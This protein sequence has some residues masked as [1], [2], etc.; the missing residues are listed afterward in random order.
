MDVE[1]TMDFILEQLAQVV[2][3]QARTDTRLDRMAEQQART[4]RRLDRAIGLAVREARAERKR[5]QELFREFDEKITQL[6]TAQLITEDK[7]QRFIDERH[8]TNGKN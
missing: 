5:R 1:K 2:A 6:A 3:L 7:L 4:D 8:G